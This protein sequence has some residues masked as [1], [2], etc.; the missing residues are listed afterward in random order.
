[1]RT[2]SGSSERFGVMMRKLTFG[3]L[4]FGS[5]RTRR[6]AVRK[7]SAVI[8]G[9][10]TMPPPRDSEARS[11]AH[12]VCRHLARHANDFGFCA[13][14]ELPHR[15]ATDRVH[16]DANVL[17]EIASAPWCFALAQVGGRRKE[18]ERRAHRAAHD[19]ARVVQIAAAQCEIIT[20]GDQ[21]DVVCS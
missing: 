8:R 5:T 18:R 15:A 3:M 12:V 10:S 20:V 21:V 1:M 17:G 9:N 14:A 4:S 6:P 2:A 7:A 19:V 16:P 11:E 13:V